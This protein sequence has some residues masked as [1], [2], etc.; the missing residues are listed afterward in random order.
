MIMQISRG[1][2]FRA[3]MLLLLVMSRFANAGTDLPM[4]ISQAGTWYVE[5]VLDEKVNTAFLL[6]TGSGYVSL[7]EKTF[8]KIRDESSTQFRRHIRA[9]MANGKIISVPV[10]SVAKLTLGAN[11]TL[12]DVEVTVLASSDRDIL[13][14]NAITAMQPLTI[15]LDPPALKAS[16][17]IQKS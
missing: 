2:V 1:V 9:A 7:S 16:C 4:T 11:C 6:D 10:Y 13:G 3:V 14:L 5:G 15:Q 17:P 8:R 12:T